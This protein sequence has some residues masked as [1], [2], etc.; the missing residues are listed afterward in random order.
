MVEHDDITNAIEA[1]DEELA[2]QLMERHIDALLNAVREQIEKM[3]EEDEP[4][5]AGA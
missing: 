5:N 4:E 3:A 1:R 2:V